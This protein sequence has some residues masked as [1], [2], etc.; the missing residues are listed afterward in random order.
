VAVLDQRISTEV[1]DVDTITSCLVFPKAMVG[2]CAM[3]YVGTEAIMATVPKMRRYCAQPWR[4]VRDAMPPHAGFTNLL[5]H[6]N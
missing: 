1:R 2:Y 4:D 6:V 3:R 5:I